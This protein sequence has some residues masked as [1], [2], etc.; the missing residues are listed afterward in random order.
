[1]KYKIV[2]DSSANLDALSNLP[3]TSVPLHIT[4]GEED[5]TDNAS[6]NLDLLEHALTTCK[7]SSTACPG[8]DDWIT[9]FGDA[10]VVFCITITSTLSGSCA[11]AMLAKK[12]YE[13]QFPHRHVHIID[14]LSTGPEMVLI[15]EK[16][17]EMILKDM[18]EADILREIQEYIKHT[19]LLFSLECLKNLA[20]NGRV[21]HT[22]AGLAGILGIRIVGQAS[23][24]GELALL[25][26]CR[27]EQRALA[28]IL[29]FMK[30]KGYT[31][32]KVR[33]V[34]NRNITA[35]EKLRSLILDT[36]GSVDIQIDK[37]K[38]LCSYYAEKGGLLIGFE[39]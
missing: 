14:S 25:T 10:Q 39:G 38:A 34:H 33:I 16:L 6:V 31:G 26:K 27:G 30:E 12:E 2:A 15:I 1:M 29:R 28:E 24:R 32:G 17:Q 19:H 23:D 5:F 22:I 37:T 3:F 9:A 20:N 4:V 7:S 35:A 13:E 8:L 11:S 36:F 21:S 18:A